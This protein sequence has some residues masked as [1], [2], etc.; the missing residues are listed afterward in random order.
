MLQQTSLLN[1]KIKVFDLEKFRRL[2]ENTE[3][4]YKKIISIHSP[5]LKSD[6]VFNSDGFHH[7]RYD[8]TR[9]ERSKESQRSKFLFFNKAVDII[10]KSTTIQEYRRSVMPVGH[11]DRSG[12][13]K[14]KSVEWFGFYAI[15][16]FSD[17]I[18]VMTVIRRIGGNSGQ[19]H[20]WSVMPFWTLSN[21]QRIIG[22][23][24]IM[25]N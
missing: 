2:R 21:K 23:K 4:E 9:A 22:S 3:L 10:R 5:A 6:V 1:Q 17:Q 8:N 11:P 16:S 7:L 20:F 18:R 19:Y 15:T 12:F 13:R 14:T 25:D 24:I